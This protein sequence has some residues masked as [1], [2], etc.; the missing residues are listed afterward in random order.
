MSDYEDDWDD[1]EDDPATNCN[2]CGGSGRCACDMCMFEE[3]CYRC[4]GPR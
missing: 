4:G 2:H 1:D 3:Y